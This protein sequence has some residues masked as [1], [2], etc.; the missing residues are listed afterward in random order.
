MG[1]L[2]LSHT[3]YIDAP[4]WEKE[5]YIFLVEVKGQLRSPEV[6]HWKYCYHNIARRETAT[7]LKLST[8]MPHI[9]RNNDNLS[10][11]VGSKGIGRHQR[12]NT[13]NLVIMISQEGKHWKFSNFVNRCDILIGK[14]L[15][16]WWRFKVIW[17]YYIWR[18]E[19][20]THLILHLEIPYGNEC[21]KHL[22]ILL[23]VKYY[24]GPTSP[25]MY[26]KKNKT[27]SLFFLL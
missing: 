13:D 19:T 20:M 2:E 14:S 1:N 5:P 23:E 4:D 6:K 9:K 21:K 17:G 7:V 24:S 3:W 11:L 12:S 27:K 10:F 18:K 15:L 26:L 25:L 22:L 8:W 16:F